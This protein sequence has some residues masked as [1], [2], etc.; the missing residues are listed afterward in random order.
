MTSA[1]KIL[2]PTPLRQYTE[3]LESIEIE[4]GSVGEALRQLITRYE[5]LRNHL[6]S[7]DGRLRDFV[8]VY[9]NEEDIR[10]LEREETDVKEGDEIR[11]IPSIAG[12]SPPR[13]PRPPP[14]GHADERGRALS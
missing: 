9:L 1:I 14:L 6:Y 8:N 11:I 13:P 4:A 10:Y 5:P 3:G 12:G 7:E 2:V